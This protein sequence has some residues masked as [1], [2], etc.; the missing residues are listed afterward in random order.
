MKKLIHLTVCLFAPLLM[1]GTS[2]NA[3]TNAGTF[4]FAVVPPLADRISADTLLY[5]GWSGMD[6]LLGQARPSPLSELWT[7]EPTADAVFQLLPRVLK[8]REL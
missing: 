7:N 6:A 8:V 3:Q 5:V 2:L 4:D 1:S